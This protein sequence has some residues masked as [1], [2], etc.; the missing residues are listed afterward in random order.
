MKINFSSKTIEV[1]K[2]FANKA[3]RFGTEEYQMLVTAMQDLPDFK[4]VIKATNF[5]TLQS[6]T[7]S[8]GVPEV[9][10]AHRLCR[11]L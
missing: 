6:H 2:T 4:I 8:Q 3:S 5:Y 10:S 1:T 9:V 11:F 7:P